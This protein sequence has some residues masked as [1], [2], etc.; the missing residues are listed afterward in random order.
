MRGPTQDC[1][2]QSKAKQRK[3]GLVWLK[4]SRP[5]P[6]SSSSSVLVCDDELWVSGLEEAEEVKQMLFFLWNFFGI[7]F[8]VQK[9]N[10]T[11]RKRKKKGV[12]VVVVT[13]S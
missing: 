10:K 8:E 1:C 12:G 6:S 5:P 4:H 13:D 2:L 11:K 3:S 9:Q 7:G